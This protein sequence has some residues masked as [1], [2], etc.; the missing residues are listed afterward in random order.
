[1]PWK[2]IHQKQEYQG[3]AEPE[4]IKKRFLDPIFPN[5][6]YFFDSFKDKEKEKILKGI[7]NFFLTALIKI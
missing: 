2:S 4:V 1:L 3:L 6:N 5:S 7:Q